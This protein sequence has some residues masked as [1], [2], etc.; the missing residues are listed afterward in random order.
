[1]PQN[2]PSPTGSW[3]GTPI[4]VLLVD[5]QRFI[6]LALER[7]FATEPDI[8]LHCCD[9]ADDALPRANAIQ[10]TVILQDLVMPGIDGLSLVALY[11]KNAA[12]ARTPI[13]VLSGNEDADSRARSLAAGADDYLLKLPA[14]DVLLACIR[15]H[16]TGGAKQGTAAP[17]QAVSAADLCA[18]PTLDREVIAMFCDRDGGLSTFGRSTHQAVHSGR[19]IAGC[20]GERRH[21]I[22]ERRGVEDDGAQLEGKF[23]DRWREAAGRVVPEARR[24]PRQEP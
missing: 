22:K 13:I 14:K 17:A 20:D 23:A 21:A 3:S 2:T 8:Q 24:R 6:G 16:A 18:D 10:P 1:M 9:K 7:L 15:T 4:T 11:R 5:D 19:G 12:T